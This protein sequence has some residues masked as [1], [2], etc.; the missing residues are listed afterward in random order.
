LPAGAT[1]ILLSI[2]NLGQVSG[3]YNL[4]PRDYKGGAALWTGGHF[5]A[6]GSAGP[7]AFGAAEVFSAN[8]TPLED[9]PSAV[10]DMP[11]GSH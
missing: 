2:N 7:V 1:G 5:K 3:G 8:L 10:P 9:P 6:L 11:P 4:G